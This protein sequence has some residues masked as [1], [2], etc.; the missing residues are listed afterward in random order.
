MIVIMDIS[1]KEIEVLKEALGF[2]D[3]VKNTDSDEVDQA[4]HTLID[5][6]S[7]M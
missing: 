5:V 1:E 6:C 7:R 4:I 2:P 3:D